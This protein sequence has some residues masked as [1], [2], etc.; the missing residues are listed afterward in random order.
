MSSARIS[1]E[2]SGTEPW[3][4]GFVQYRWISFVR[5]M[6][7]ASSATARRPRGTPPRAPAWSVVNANFS[8]AASIR[9]LVL[10]GKFHGD[11]E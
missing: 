7:G 8:S 3:S 11:F 6:I 5:K 10:A 4:F 9:A 2:G 1:S